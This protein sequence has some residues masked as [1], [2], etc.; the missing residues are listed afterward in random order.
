MPGNRAF[1]SLSSGLQEHNLSQVD[2]TLASATV[3]R[4][5]ERA[6]RLY[7]QD[8]RSLAARRGLDYRRSAPCPVVLA[9]PIRRMGIPLAIKYMKVY[10]LGAFALGAFILYGVF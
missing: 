2:S 3:E 8:R 9:P 6:H 7:E 10:A 5:V 1:G 4:F